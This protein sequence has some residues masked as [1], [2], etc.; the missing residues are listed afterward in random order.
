MKCWIVYCVLLLLN[1]T[2]ALIIPRWKVFKDFLLRHN[3]RQIVILR[4][5]DRNLLP[6]YWQGDLFLLTQDFPVCFYSCEDYLN[7]TKKD[8]N[9]CLLSSQ[10]ART[11]IF[12]DYDHRNRILKEFLV[13]YLRDQNRYQKIQTWFIYIHMENFSESQILSEFGHLHLN[14]FSDIT[15]AIQDKK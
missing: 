14:A 12:V 6:I 7:S 8:Y 9:S 10:Y 5:G 15:V 2:S 13:T 11:A 3:L 4:G 1:I